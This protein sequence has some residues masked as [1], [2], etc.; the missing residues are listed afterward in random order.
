MNKIV[1]AIAVLVFSGAA[2]ARCITNSFTKDGRLTV[3][4]TCCYGGSC[5]TTCT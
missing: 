2:H 3:C 5:T 4:T 1:L